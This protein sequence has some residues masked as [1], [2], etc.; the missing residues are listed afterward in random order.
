MLTVIGFILLWILRI[1]GILLAILLGVIGIVLFVPFTYKAHGDFQDKITIKVRFAWLCSMI[2]GRFEYV[3]TSNVELRFLVFKLYPKKVKEK[4]A[5]GTKQK[6]KKTPNNSPE[7]LNIT[8]DKAPQVEIQEKPIS[9]IEEPIKRHKSDDDLKDTK[10]KHV[11]KKQTK[12]KQKNERETTASKKE[13][14]SFVDTL[15]SYWE[16]LNRDENSGLLKHITKYVIKIIRWIFPNKISASIEFGLDDPAVTGYLAGAAS[17][18]YVVTKHKLHLVPNFNEVILRGQFNIKG[19]LFL[20][21]V[22]YYII[23]VIIDKRVRR[24]IKEVQT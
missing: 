22:L 4:K 13:S 18:L 3:E 14:N 19:R 11:L 20:F 9:F 2:N 21:Q 24:L 12:K 16:F 1:I 15:K 8:M 10:E 23:R 5:H 17:V 7:N 6:S